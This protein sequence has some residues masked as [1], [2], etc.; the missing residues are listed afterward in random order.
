MEKKIL[1]VDDEEMLRT[2]FEDAFT[3]AGYTVR[4]AAGGEE[5]L[6]ILEKED[7][8]VMFLDLNMPGMNGI[9][10]CRRIRKMNAMAVIHAVT[11]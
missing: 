5:A 4:S 10:L 6:G 1:V 2:L 9:E 8:H 3:S 11:G 7:I